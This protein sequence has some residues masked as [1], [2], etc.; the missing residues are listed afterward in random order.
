MN[1]N[2]RNEGNLLGILEG[3]DFQ[4]CFFKSISENIHLLLQKQSQLFQDD[5]MEQLQFGIQILLEATLQVKRK[6]V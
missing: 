2:D 3:Y 4:V 1:L 6:Q 5:G